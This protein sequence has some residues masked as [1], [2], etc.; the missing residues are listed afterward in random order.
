MSLY[1]DQYGSPF[2]STKNADTTLATTVPTTTNPDVATTVAINDVTP[3]NESIIASPS[4]STSVVHTNH[5]ASVTTNAVTDTGSHSI[6]FSP[7]EKTLLGII[8]TMFVFSM[9]FCGLGWILTK[10]FFNKKNQ[11]EKKRY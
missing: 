11:R 1:A 5:V 2:I 7:F 3:D 8:P 4:V 9:I 6:E 10:A